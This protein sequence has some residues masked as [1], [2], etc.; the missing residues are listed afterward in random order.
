MNINSKPKL[1]YFLPVLLVFFF[2]IKPARAVCP[3]CTIAVGAGVGLSREIGVD[4]SITGLWVGAFVVSLIAWTLNWLKGKNINF[5]GKEVITIFSYYVF[6]IVPLYFSG[7]IKNPL[8]TICA[9]GLDKLLL[10][11]IVGSFAFWFASEWYIQ[12]K[13]NNNDKAYFP[14]QKVAMPLVLL[15]LLS[16]IF[17]F[18]TK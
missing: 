1:L 2:A 12:L 5:K 9:C 11:I 3:V 13:K 6:V 15:L 10:S 18:I 7:M 14:Y 16:F 17:Y 8:H 4:D